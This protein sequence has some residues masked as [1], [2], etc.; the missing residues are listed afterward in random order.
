[1]SFI[2]TMTQ[3]GRQIVHHHDD[4]AIMIMIMIMITITAGRE[5]CGGHRATDA[6][7]RAPPRAMGRAERCA[8][9]RTRRELEGAISANISANRSPA[10][11]PPAYSPPMMNLGEYLGE[12]PL[13]VLR[14]R[15]FV[16][17]DAKA[18]GNSSSLRGLHLSSSDYP[19]RATRTD[20]PR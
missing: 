4:T 1:M 10:Y 18:S 9:R 6:E 15:M 16:Q 14:A 7:W 5:R 17:I 2:V 11:V 20:Q 12:F 13:Q 8:A 19:S 3:V